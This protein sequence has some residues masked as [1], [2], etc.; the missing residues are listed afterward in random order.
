MAKRSEH[1]EKQLKNNIK[2]IRQLVKDKISNEKLYLVPK[3]GVLEETKSGRLKIDAVG[4]SH[5]YLSKSGKMSVEI[6]DHA[7]GLLKSVVMSNH[8]DILQLII[9]Y[10]F[11]DINLD[12][13]LCIYILQVALDCS[14]IDCFKLLIKEERFL[15]HINGIDRDGSGSGIVYIA[16]AS[17]YQLQALSALKKA[18]ADFNVLDSG[19]YSALQKMVLQE[20]LKP[21]KKN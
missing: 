8:T 12:E 15:K 11:L 2:H 13:S 14:G 20:T 1:A 16:A 3:T 9:D 6:K 17:K 19:G 21:S 5:A 7:G 10:N 18:G 4:G